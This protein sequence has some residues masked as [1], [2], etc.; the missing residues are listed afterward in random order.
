MQDRQGEGRVWDRRHWQKEAHLN[1]MP[2]C[3]SWAAKT[4]SK[5]TK[6]Q[7]GKE[8]EENKT[9]KKAFTYDVLC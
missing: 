2:Q 9:G 1:G 6:N 7:G 5:G 3:R 8:E 4:L